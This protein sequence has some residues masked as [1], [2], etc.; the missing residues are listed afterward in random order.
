MG[1]QIAACVA[2]RQEFWVGSPLYDCFVGT[3]LFKW[4]YPF[5]WASAT[6]FFVIRKWT[7]LFI[8]TVLA[9]V[10]D[11]GGHELYSIVG[12]NR[13]AAASDFLWNWTVAYAAQIQGAA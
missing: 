7:S 1:R 9:D 4:F 6:G 12:N 3:Q 10:E 5:V 13:G 2:H 11:L 8:S